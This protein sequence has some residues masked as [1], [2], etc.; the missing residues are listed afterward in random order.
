MTKS[1]LFLLLAVPAPA[2]VAVGVG[3]PRTILAGKADADRDLDGLDD[4]SEDMLAQEFRPWLVFDT[5]ENATKPGEPVTV[6]Q[7][8]PAGPRKPLRLRLVYTNLWEMDGGYGPSSWCRDRHIGDDQNV[9]VVVVSDDGGITF[10]AEEVLIGPF[11]WPKT[12]K[13][14]DWSGTHFKLLLS[15]GKHHHFFDSALDAKPSPHSKWYCQDDVDGKGQSFLSK[16]SGNVGEPEAHG[17]PF[18]DALAPL[19][20]PD[21]FAWD[22]RNFCGGLKCDR[23]RNATSPMASQWSRA[24]FTR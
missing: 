19:G 14:I 6:F 10:Q 18:V 20:F 22:T 23:K 11:S 13:T 3:L 21:E 1:L 8:R 2:Q 17:A 24:P 16:L 5:D 9:T 7:V 4:A 15:A 12:T